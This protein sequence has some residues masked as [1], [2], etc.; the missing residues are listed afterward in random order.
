[1][2]IDI[3]HFVEDGTHK[4]RLIMH[5]HFPSKNAYTL[6]ITTNSSAIIALRMLTIG[7]T[8]TFT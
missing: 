7:I 8:N 1:M 6:R 4:N 2:T 5:T 3:D